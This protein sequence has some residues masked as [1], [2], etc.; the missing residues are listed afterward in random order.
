LRLAAVALVAGIACPPLAACGPAEPP[1]QG[2]LGPPRILA[3]TDGQ[4]HNGHPSVRLLTHDTSLCTATLI[5]PRTVLTAAHC[6]VPGATH[7]FQFPN[8]V[9]HEVESVARHP[10]FDPTQYSPDLALALLRARVPVTPTPVASARIKLGQEV[11]IIGYGRTTYGGSDTGTKRIA[12]NTVFSIDEPGSTFFIDGTGAGTGNICGG[13][14]G[15]PALAR[16]GGVEGQVGVIRASLSGDCGKRG[17]LVLLQPNLAWLRTASRGDLYEVDGQGQVT[18]PPGLDGGAPG[19]DGATAN[20]GGG[21]VMAGPGA[22][23]KN[24]APVPP[25]VLAALL[26]AARRRP[27]DEKGPRRRSAT[28]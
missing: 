15:G 8:G 26:W 27:H 16:Y 13:D 28:H 18:V 24:A 14:S 5:G 6:V 21:C 4:E 10:R 22:G 12:S 20:G 7:T 3:I 2:G 1:P 25:L 9:R 19:G 11:T 17:M 23:G